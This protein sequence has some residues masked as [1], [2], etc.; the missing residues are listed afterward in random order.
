MTRTIAP[1]TR[2][3]VTPASYAVLA[4]AGGLA[5]GVLGWFLDP[6]VGWAARQDWLPLGG[7]LELLERVALAGPAWLQ[8]TAGALAGVVAGVLLAS[9]GTAIEV[10][11][12]DLVV[13]DGSRRQRFARGQVGTAV[14]EGRRLSV[15][16]PADVDLASTTVDGDPTTLRRVLV[17]HGWDV[18]G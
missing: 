6:V 4:V 10:S 7:P 13:V 3:D 1:R 12:E 16:D 11:R 9:Q 14:L 15:R 17:E 18:R 2:V 5:L 8:S